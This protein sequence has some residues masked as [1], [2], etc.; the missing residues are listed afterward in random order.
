VRKMTSAN[1]AKIGARD[2]GL[3][4]PGLRADVVAFDAEKII[5]RSTYLDPFQ[6]P[7]GV[8]WV[9]V[10]GAVTIEQRRHTGA[11]AGKVLRH[12]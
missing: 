3:L 8:E 9:I 4:L 1:A 5:D 10:N 12:E 7:E 6:Y 2:R 11:R